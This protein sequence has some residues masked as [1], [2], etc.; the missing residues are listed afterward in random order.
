M[1]GGWGKKKIFLI[2][3]YVNDRLKRFVFEFTHSLA[4]ELQDTKIFEPS[5]GYIFSKFVYFLLKHWY[6]PL[7]VRTEQ[8]TLQLNIFSKFAYSLLKL[9]YIPLYIHT[10]QLFILM[11]PVYFAYQ[12]D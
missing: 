9:W 4:A 12:P 2:K 1:P 8:L 7:Y 3:R 6:V 10:D 5:I 11:A